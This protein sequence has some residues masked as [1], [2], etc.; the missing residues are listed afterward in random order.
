MKAAAKKQSQCVHIFLVSYSRVFERKEKLI[1]N[2][3]DFSEKGKKKSF[4]EVKAKVAAKV[5]NSARVLIYSQRRVDS[6]P[7]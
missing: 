4:V 6:V 2:S 1:K 5:I 3:S 7:V